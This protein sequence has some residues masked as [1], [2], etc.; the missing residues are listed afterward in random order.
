[1]SVYETT[2]DAMRTKYEA[3]NSLREARETLSQYKLTPSQV[4]VLDH[5]DGC[6]SLGAIAA[7]IGFSRGNLTG[8]AKRLVAKGLAV[9]ERVEKNERRKKL[10]RTE[11]GT[12]VLNELRKA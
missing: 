11:A 8:I 1:M 12:Q 7:R 4:M 3:A 2:V 6:T 10:T 9:A 5:A